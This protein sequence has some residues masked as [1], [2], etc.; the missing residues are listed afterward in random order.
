MAL[1]DADVPARQPIPTVQHASALRNLAKVVS[2]PRLHYVVRMILTSQ[3]QGLDQPIA[4][5]Q[6]FDDPV[7]QATGIGH[8]V[9]V[10]DHVETFPGSRQS[11][12]DAIVRLQE[13]D[14]SLLVAADQRQQNDIAL[15]A[16]EIVDRRD[17]DPL[18]HGPRH[19]ATQQKHLPGVHGEN[20]DLRRFVA[21]L[22]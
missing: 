1:S 14:L 4:G 18:E 11:D 22:Q 5:S 9:H 12:A 8:L 15:F 2:R 20:G 21:L 19:E 10:A 6:L 13:P 7:P 3:R 16:L 17:T